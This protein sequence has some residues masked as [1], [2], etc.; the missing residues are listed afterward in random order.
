MKKFVLWMVTVML[1]LTAFSQ[2]DT[3]ASKS[4][5][6]TVPVVVLPTRVA[7][8]VAKDLVRLDSVSS[9]LE[10]EKGK[11]RLLSLNN[12]VKD[13]LIAEKDSSLKAYGAKDSVYTKYSFLK[14]QQTNAYKDGYQKVKA[15]YIKEKRINKFYQILITVLATTNLVCLLSKH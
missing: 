10:T 9:E 1:S 15:S 2:A 13:S 12:K 6:D 3:L 11:N 4:K 7:K 8:E 5:R 14:D